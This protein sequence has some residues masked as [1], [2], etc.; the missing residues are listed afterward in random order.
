MDRT[1][2]VPCCINERSVRKR[3]LTAELR[4]R[5]ER[6]RRSEN[7]RS[8]IESLYIA[9]THL[10]TQYKKQHKLQ[11]SEIGEERP[12]WSDLQMLPNSLQIPLCLIHIQPEILQGHH[13]QFFFRYKN[14][15]PFFSSC[16]YVFF[17]KISL[18]L[19]LLL[20]CGFD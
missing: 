2:N 4:E 12:T 18:L 7:G 5:A 15:C 11:L 16:Y 13:C 19:L 17:T 1:D 10:K 9:Y 14:K 6:P 20:F 8:A 3:K